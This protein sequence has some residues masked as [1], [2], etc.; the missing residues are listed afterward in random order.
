MHRFT[1]LLA[2]VIAIQDDEK[3]LRERA[4]ALLESGR[5]LEARPLLQ[6]YVRR[7]PKSEHAP[8]ALYDLA[9]TYNPRMPDE[10]AAALEC[11]R[12]IHRDYP[13]SE[14]VEWSAGE[15][16]ELAGWGF[17]DLPDRLA[18]GRD[19]AFDVLRLPG[20]PSSYVFW[21]IPIDEY[22]KAL[23]NADLENIDLS[24]PREKWQRAGEAKLEFPG[25][26]KELQSGRFTLTLEQPGPYVVEETIDGF[27]KRHALR[28]QTFGMAVKT[29]PRRALV[30][31]VEPQTGRPL[32]GIDVTV[33]M[34][35]RTVRR[36][37]GRDGL[38]LVDAPTTFVATAEKLDEIHGIALDV[39]APP[40]EALVYVTTDRP[41]YRPGQTVHFKAIRRDRAAAALGFTPGRKVRVDVR[42]PD[43]RVVQTGETAWSDAGTLSGSF[44]LADEPPLGDWAVIVHVPC[45]AR[46]AWFT[47]SEDLPYWHRTFRVAEYRKPEVRVSVDFGGAAPVLGQ[48]VKAR[49]RAEYYFGGPTA[50]ADVEWSV[51]RAWAPRDDDWPRPPEDPRVWF[52]MQDKEEDDDE[53]YVE[54]TVA[55]GKGRTGDDGTLDIEFETEPGRREQEFV[56]SAT[57]RDLSRLTAEGAG[58]IRATPA[59]VRVGLRTQRMFYQPGDRAQARVRVASADGRPL[60]NAAVEVAA[61][62]AVELPTDEP[63]RA[64]DVE[65]ESIFTGTS[66][67]DA[68][69]VTTVEVPLERVG[70]LRLRARAKD[71]AGRVAEDRADL[72]VAGEDAVGDDLEYDLA[73]TPDR[74]IYEEG[75]TVKLMVRTFLKPVT[76]LLTIESDTFHEARVVELR[77]RCEILEIPVRAE[78][79]PNVVLQLAGFKDGVS[80][81]GGYEICVFPKRRLL[82]VEVSTDRATYGPRQKAK[83][84]VTTRQGGAPVSAE[85]ELAVVDESV[86]SLARDRAEDIRAFFNRFRDHDHQL[87]GTAILSDSYASFRWS[88]HLGGTP[89]TGASFAEEGAKQQFAAEFAPAETRWWFPDTLH[90]AAHVKTGPDGKAEVEIDTP[91]S[92]TTWRLTARAVAGADRFGVAASSTVTRKDVILRLVAPRF[93][94]ERDEGVVSTIVHNDLPEEAEFVVRFNGGEKK[95]K[96]A[97]KG[98]G[99]LDWPVRAAAVGAMKLKAEALS[100]AQSDAVELEVP[101]L[102]HGPAQQSIAGGRV[103]GSWAGTVSLPAGAAA[104]SIEIVVTPPGIAAV[105][106][107]LPF[108]AGYPYGCVEQ[109]MSRFLPSVVAAG[110]MKRLGIANAALEKDLPF[111]VDAGLQKLYGYQHE[112]GG[113]GWW[114]D[115]RTD[116]RMTAY[117][118]Y[119][120]ATARKAGVP[121]DE[122]TLKRGVNA[123]RAMP[124]TPY[125]VFAL[126]TAGDDVSKI[127][128]EPSDDVERAWLVLAGRKALAKEIAWTSPAKA[129]YPD[130]E[131]AAILLRAIASVDPKDPRVAPL[132]DW[133]MSQRRGGAWMSTLDTA[134]AV[135]AFVEL[136]AVEKEPSVSVKW[137]GEVVAAKA[138]RIRLDPSRAKAENRVEVTSDALA[139]A[140]AVLRY[141]STAEHVAPERGA[142]AVTRRFE[143]AVLEKG[144]KRWE[145]LESGS[146]VKVADEIRVVVTVRA[147]EAAEYVM[148]ECPIAAGTEPRASESD[149]YDWWSSWYGRRELR[150]DKVCVAAASVGDGEHEFTFRLR[151]TLPGEYHVM[152][153]VAFAMYETDKRGTSGEFVLRVR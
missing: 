153:A 117:V 14:W 130:V 76:A 9:R 54:G 17:S 97:S 59:A 18:P 68:S 48:K 127:E 112:D 15:V 124:S 50:G 34:K 137:N 143:R 1:L 89:L 75:E 71:N 148:V 102:P 60:A 84:I 109:T 19:L 12:R 144:G 25:H 111:M 121:V 10:R 58:R 77:K 78:H 81:G 8:K 95:L 39:E 44:R 85:V 57:V 36:R 31:C 150:D 125:A 151:P 43:G 141:R 86:L 104:E 136:A 47:L 53:W 128:V 88:P 103:S 94:T 114:R 139:F 51:G 149:D 61:F 140:S 107:A 147:P 105:R 62:M 138:R 93:Y 27:V 132:V 7:F 55:S 134:Y 6:D 3:T 38:V 116:E 64:R 70:R 24:V 131:R 67:T 49:I 5:R 20:P 87:A 72:W 56:V 33:R 135:Y 120:L 28:L 101:V 30:Y 108:L 118:V 37:T 91:D 110:A 45:R 142:L 2:L 23:A 11:L 152:P 13:S 74:Q 32:D 16:Q 22:R 66:R 29:L 80:F 106:E 26:G 146:E 41:I 82:D 123:L 126:A 96:V 40:E 122:E 83:V 92:L 100:K 90:Y 129:R 145:H 73:V 4:G 46:R 21:R 113:W 35:D 63:L 42:D 99:R 52:A 119:G 133:L 65:F 79:A 69:G 98:V 115:D